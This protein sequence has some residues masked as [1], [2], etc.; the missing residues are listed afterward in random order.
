[1]VANRKGDAQFIKNVSPRAKLQIYYFLF[2]ISYLLSIIFYL[3]SFIFYLSIS[4]SPAAHHTILLIFA[5]K[6]SD[7]LAFRQLHFACAARIIE[8]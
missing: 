5:A 7:N 8:A 6:F 3:L 1:M 2:I 4:H